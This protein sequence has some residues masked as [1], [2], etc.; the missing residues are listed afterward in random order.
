MINIIVAIDNHNGIGK[1]NKLLAYIKEDL[2]YFKNITKD[3]IVVMGRKTYESLPQKPLKDRENII[4]TRENLNFEGAVV[5]NNI[6]DVLELARKT[7][8]SDV[9]I[10]GGQSIYEQFMPYADKLYITHIFHE[11]LADTFFPDIGDEWEIENVQATKESIKGEYSFV[12]VVYK[13]I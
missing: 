1:D 13:R 8:K 12:W 10:C 9:F 11:F 3:N 4:L 6:E 5:Y 7:T 2:Q